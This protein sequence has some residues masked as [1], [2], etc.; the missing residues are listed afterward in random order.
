MSIKVVK[1]AL[2]EVN[3]SFD[4]LYSYLIPLGLESSVEVGIRVSVPFGG[5]NVLKVGMVLEVDAVETAPKSYKYIYSIEDT[6]PILNPEQIGMVY[7]LVETTFCTYHDAI[8]TILPS[9]YT[10]KVSRRYCL[11][12]SKVDIS[13]LDV[14]E[15]ELIQKLQSKKDETKVSNTIKR[16][17]NS[18]VVKTLMKK[19]VI[20]TK[21]VFDSKSIDSKSKLVNLSPKFLNDR[22]AFQLSEVQKKV[23]KLLEEGGTVSVNEIEYNVSHSKKAIQS[24]ERLGVIDV[25]EYQPT[26]YDLNNVERYRSNIVLTTEQNEIFEQVLSSMN[27]SKPDCFLIHGVTGSGKT[28]IFEKLMQK[29]LDMGRGVIL[30]VPEISLT[31]QMVKRFTSVFGKRIALIHSGLSLKQREDEYFRIR[32]GLADI[33]IGTRS[34]IFV[35]LKNIGLIIM[36]EEGEGS[37]KSERSPRYSTKDVARF[38]CKYHNAIMVLASATPSVESYYLAKRG[39]YRLLTLNSRYNNS[40]LPKTTI[41]DMRKERRNGNTLELSNTLMVE[42]LKNLENKEQ[43]ILLLNRRGYNTSIIC[44]D[45]GN[46]IECRNC[47]VPMTY[48]KANSSLICHYCGYS[49]AEVRQ[50]PKCHSNSIR[51]TGYGT[52]KVVEDL[53]KI[54]P[55]AK[56]LRMDAD[57]TFSKY[58]HEKF[59][60]R[61]ANG[62]YDILVGTQMVGRGLD[63]PNVTLTGIISAD[64]MLYTGEYRSFEKTFSLITQVI[65]RSGRGDKLGR[66]IL[67]T[68]NPE[69][70]IL[71]QAMQQDYLSFFKEELALRKLHTFPP[72]CDICTIGLSS[73]DENVV[74]AGCNTMMSTIADLIKS[75]NFKRPL[76]VLSPIKFTH[77]RIDGKFRYK[78]VIKCKNNPDFR[79][80]IRS[81]L[82]EFY[83]SKVP[84][85]IV[86]IDINGDVY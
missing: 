14:D 48:H 56:I 6:K 15:A 22:E 79:N 8:R 33:V 10:M 42:L 21:R 46:V 84:K 49:I 13:N 80:L 18:T 36:D 37:Y 47:S 25:F 1:V 24:L 29:C 26:D 2:S 5:G 77:E 69:H 32:D 70:Y 38:R 45:C 11:D 75:L 28:A 52:Q 9:T 61:F 73:I 40:P 51:Y 30:L 53:E 67:Q 63:F 43:S 20:Y 57:T 27:L 59:F 72:I 7:Y 71:Q 17:V 16:Y 81:V 60:D 82:K 12:I 44:S 3:A 19:K 76:R 31:P 62:E 86:F 39:V 58:T 35:P 23:V 74:Q 50:C 41:V 78:I 64:G 83:K 65:G 4:M 54:F 68:Y 34:A 85:L 55:K 66:A